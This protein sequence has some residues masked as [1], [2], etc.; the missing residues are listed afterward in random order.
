MLHSVIASCLLLVLVGAQSTPT[1]SATPTPAPRGIAWLIFVDDLHMDFRHTGRIRD[2][3]HFM[4]TALIRHEDVVVM[5]ASGQ[6]AINIGAPSD[7]TIVEATIRRVAAAGL[8]PRAISEEAKYL[9]GEVD[10]R[11]AMTF[12]SASALLET[13]AGMGD[14]RG[15]MLYISNGYHSERGRALTSLLARA[16]QQAQVMI[17]AVNAG[18]LA[19]AVPMDTSGVDAEFWKGVVASRRE[20]LRAIAEPTGGSALLDDVDAAGTV[21]RV[22]A[23]VLT[24]K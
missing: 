6:S 12:S 16:A 11:L 9:T 15:A 22:R 17:F 10:V 7:R 3:L 20:T 24:V 19:G 13:V 23:A 4:S 5:R 18:A 21:S 14:R 8:Q 2:L 1:R